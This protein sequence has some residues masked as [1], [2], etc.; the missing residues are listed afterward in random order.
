LQ[1]ARR[2]ATAEV[3]FTSTTARQGVSNTADFN[4]DNISLEEAGAVISWGESALS[5]G[6]EIWNFHGI[7]NGNALAATRGIVWDNAGTGTQEIRLAQDIDL[8][9]GSV[10]VNSGNFLLSS[11]VEGT[12]NFNSAGFLINAGATLTTNFS[13]AAGTEWRKVGE[14]NLVIQG[15]GN[16]EITL[17]VGGGVQRFDENLNSLY[18]G[19]VR[20]DREGGYA[21]KTIRLS[22]G[23]AKIVLMRDGQIS[24]GDAF[25]FGIGGGL[26]NLNGQSL[27]WDQIN[28]TDSGA[29]FG[30]FKLDDAT[31]APADSVF[32]F[33]GAGT[34]KGG[35]LDGNAEAYSYDSETKTWSGNGGG[36]TAGSLKVV[37][38]AADSSSTWK[39]TGTSENAGGFEVRS[40]TLVLQGANTA[41]ASYSDSGDW[42]YAVLES[43][44]GVTVNNGA[45]FRLA[46]HALMTAN[47]TVNNGTFEMTD[48]VKAATESVCGGQREDVSDIVGLRGNVALASESATM[49]RRSDFRQRQF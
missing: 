13:G 30:N 44:G 11:D 25:T 43:A 34:F 4:G 47:I 37:Y 35:F 41:H 17:N 33:T 39:L 49:K 21:A 28:H 36:A 3:P 9:A 8:G 7:T 5:R 32:T 45:T 22:A 26:L 27:T 14:G 46:D 42:T 48:V 29:K 18:L 23:V 31:S 10:T 19:E 6:N 20:L 40:G 38:D 1:S 16:H 15:S 24:G 2:A 12:T